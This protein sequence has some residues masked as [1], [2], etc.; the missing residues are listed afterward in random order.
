MNAFRSYGTTPLRISKDPRASEWWNEWSMA[1]H[2]RHFLNEDEVNLSARLQNNALRIALNYAISDGSRT[3]REPQLRA[4]TSFVDWQ[5]EQI[6]REVRLWGS[7]D[8][9]RLQT[10]ILNTLR[11]RPF[12]RKELFEQ[13]A[14]YSVS[15]VRKALDD[16]QWME[17]VKLTHDGRYALA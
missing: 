2:T 9:V 6:K 16:L 4:A 7:D 12:G 17:T 3:I 11:M 1:N 5:Y 14:R 15:T 8:N 13:L 10:R